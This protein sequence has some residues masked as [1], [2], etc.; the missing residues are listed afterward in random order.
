MTSPRFAQKLGKLRTDEV[1][2]MFGPKVIESFNRLYDVL[3][4][5]PGFDSQTLALINDLASPRRHS[6]PVALAALTRIVAESAEY[7]E[8]RCVPPLK[9]ILRDLS[10]NLSGMGEEQKPIRV[11]SVRGKTR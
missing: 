11:V 5:R 8:H 1:G 3:Q 4:D 10:D 6:I 2:I 7:A 9:E